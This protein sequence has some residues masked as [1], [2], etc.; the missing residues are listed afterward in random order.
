MK[1]IGLLGGGWLLTGWMVA[2]LAAAPPKGPA[3]KASVWIGPTG[4]TRLPDGTIYR[5][6]DAKG[7]LYPF[8]EPVV[9][10]ILDTKP[11]P[12]ASPKP[13]KTRLRAGRRSPG[14][15]MGLTI[16]PASL[17]FGAVPVG[18]SVMR[19]AG[20]TNP[21]PVSLNF[22][23]MAVQGTSLGQFAWGDNWQGPFQLAPG[24]SMNYWVTFRPTRKGA[25]SASVYF[26][27]DLRLNLT[28]VG[29]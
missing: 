18:A 23:A 1:W 12:F 13:G 21:N 26:W 16:T 6:T 27:G 10:L 29:Q 25:A 11:V 14:E 9:V 17:D 8:K 5:V 4:E 3:V 7:R 20:L 2:G 19:A 24:A 15:G 22:M 28:G